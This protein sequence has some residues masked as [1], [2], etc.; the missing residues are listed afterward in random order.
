MTAPLNFSPEKRARQ[1]WA[2]LI[3]IALSVVLTFLAMPL[4]SGAMLLAAGILAVA[5]AVFT[6]VHWRCDKCRELLPLLAPEEHGF[7]CN[8]KSETKKCCE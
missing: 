1:K 2:T 5:W 7:E 4:K 8:S 3:L 6:L